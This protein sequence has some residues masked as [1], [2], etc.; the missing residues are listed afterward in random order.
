MI[1]TSTSTLSSA[2]KVCKKSRHSETN[3][4]KSTDKDKYRCRTGNGGI[5][6]CK[7]P[8]KYRF[9][10]GYQIMF[11]MG[12]KEGYIG[13][14]FNG[15]VNAPTSCT[16]LKNKEPVIDNCYYSSMSGWE[17]QIC[18][19]CKEG[20]V[21][22][23]NGKTCYTHSQATNLGSDNYDKCKNLDKNDATGYCGECWWPYRFQSTSSKTCSYGNL[24]I[25][26]IIGCFSL[27]ITIFS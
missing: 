14:H 27:I 15:L 10:D 18:W 8:G 11:C 13:Q 23:K 9:A 24:I 4:T 26:V 22:S 16:A 6:G 21:A 20:Y 25:Y 5:A 19:A 2:C 1:H 7:Y 3:L 17:V 12:C